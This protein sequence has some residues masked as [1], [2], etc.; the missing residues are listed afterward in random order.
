MNI[1]VAGSRGQLGQALQTDLKNHLIIPL[2][3]QDLDIGD[4]NSVLDQVNVLKPDI[5]INAA[6]YNDVD[7]AETDIDSAYRVNEQ[8]PRNL[9]IASSRQKIPLV[10]VSTDYVF[11]GTKK[12]PYIEEDAANPLSIYG[13]SKLAGELAVKRENP[14]HFIIRTAWLFHTEGDN[15]IKKMEILNARGPI[16]VVDDQYSSPTYAPHLVQKI[17][18]LIGTES[19]GLYHMAGSG[20]ASRYEQLKFYF[21]QRKWPVTFGAVKAKEFPQKA[22]RPQFSPLITSRGEKFVLPPWQDGVC[23]YIQRLISKG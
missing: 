15:F 4:L 14:R 16:R 6:S 9:A 11:D 23:E 20:V 13:K 2:S 5:I 1:L 10:H 3:H 7:G 12:S 8:G 19:F 17:S 21:E 22:K 18:Q